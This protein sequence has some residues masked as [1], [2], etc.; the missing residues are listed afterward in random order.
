MKLWQLFIGFLPIIVIATCLPA[1]R[2]LLEPKQSPS[3]NPTP[4]RGV[5]QPFDTSF[6]YDNRT[7]LPA[8]AQNTGVGNGTSPR[9]VVLPHHLTASTLIAQGLSLLKTPPPKTIVLL[10]PNHANT[11]QCAIV[12]SKNNWD[13]PF[14]QVLVDQYLLNDFLDTK[15]ICLDDSAVAIEHGL[16]GLVPFIKYYLPNTKIVP[17]ALKND[18]DPILLNNFTQKLVSL[19]TK[20]VI[21]GSIDFSHGLSKSESTKKDAV[22]E[23]LLLTFNYPELLKLS[24]EYLDSPVSLVAILKILDSEKTKPNILAH[25]DSSVF[26]NQPMNVTSYF[27][28]SGGSSSS[29]TIRHPGLD[30]AVGPRRGRSIPSG[31]SFTLLFGGD[32]MLGRSVNTRMIKYQDFLWPFQKISALLS[33]ADLSIINL[34]SPFRSG[35]R[36]T[37]G[38]MVFCAD[39][40]SV[41]GLVTAGIDVVNIA[42][43]HIFNQGQEGIDETIAI[44]NN[45]NIA[46]VGADPRVRPTNDP[47]VDPQKSTF[48]LKN[49]K[50]T[51]L[52]FPDIA[53]VSQEI[54]TATPDNIRA[55]ISAAKKDSDLVIATFHWGNEYSHRSLHQVE[56]AHLA[57]D[58]GADVVIGHHP[59]WVQEVETYLGKPIYYSLGNLV[60]DQMWSEETRTGLV[61]KLNFSGSTLISQEQIPI[62]IFDYG[63]PATL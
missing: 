28:I 26:N 30:R 60:F 39:P 20:T 56:L 29:S 36:P 27:L 14:G 5:N 41:E 23:K 44:L 9:V 33:S 38:G 42:N 51:F 35:C 16:A 37:D 43:N 6:A 46:F 12:S 17:F 19:S 59:H 21:L 55:Q 50:I 58:S 18:L 57:V 2:V 25:S 22:T 54:A 10:S 31:N 40:R 63:Q 47:R 8:V 61:V 13:T 15:T 32:V 34:E 48:T 3:L 11:G 45:N 49:T 7:F 1:G 4:I 62:K 53:S 52:G 24:S